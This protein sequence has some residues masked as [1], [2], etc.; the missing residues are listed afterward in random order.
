MGRV[1]SD[2]FVQNAWALGDRWRKGRKEKKIQNAMAGWDDDPETVIKEVFN[3]DRTEGMALKKVY[4][5]E[6]ETKKAE[7]L[8]VRERKMGTLKQIVTFLGEAD[9]DPNSDLGA[10]YDK[11]T[12]ILTDTLGMTPEEVTYYRGAITANPSL[13]KTLGKA[14]KEEK[15]LQGVPGTQFFDPKER[16]V[17]H[18]VPQAYQALQVPRGD[19]GRDVVTYDKNTG[20]IGGGQGAPTAPAQPDAVPSAGPA[21]GSVP[22]RPANPQAKTIRLNNPGGLKD[23]AFARSLPGY[24]GGEGGFA[25]FETPE[26]GLA[27]AET[28]LGGYLK[29]GFNTPSK[30]INRWAPIGPEN[31]AESVRNYIGHV[32]GKLGIGPND[33][34]PPE[35]LREAV[36]AM[37][38]FEA[39]GNLPTTFV[40]SSPPRGG[41]AIYSTP[42]KPEKPP[43]P[44]F[45]QLSPQEVADRGL[46]QRVNWQI[47][48]EGEIKMIGPAKSMPSAPK[49]GVNEDARAQAVTD[50]LNA[51]I[52]STKALM[53]H[54]GLPRIVGVMGVIPNIPGGQAADA[55]AQLDT[56]KSQI[57]LNVLQAMR[58]MSKTGGALGNV[59]NYEIKTL[60]NN[61]AALK[62]TQSLPAFKKQLGIIVERMETMKRRLYENRGSVRA[63]PTGR[64]IPP[65]AIK[66]LRENPSGVRRQQ[67]D[68]VFGR[69]AAAR[70][71]G[72]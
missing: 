70:V 35:R 63:S 64:G 26:A 15:L 11:L 65:A 39:G 29:K 25:V 4:T 33:P 17:V 49:P 10:A 9:E 21:T 2:Q 55:A 3:I 69:G 52:G 72:K 58:D 67:F 1:I 43:E 53:N 61:L 50:N 32:A 47:S 40:G 24:R 36:I 8:K 57:S 5:T 27:A 23:G 46:D 68:S 14:D 41:G 31:S 7:A 16:K 30:V 12:P 28:N 62:Q 34:I 18:T 20:A 44:G 54:P 71:L 22:N 42:G 51:L 66:M 60:E 37:A 45:R 6:Q 19:G 59:S 13:L 48:G 56:L 38:E